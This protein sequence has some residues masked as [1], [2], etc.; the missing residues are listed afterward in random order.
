MDDFKEYTVTCKTKDCVNGG[1]GI[2]ML[3]PTVDPY[4]I[5]GPC[6]QPIVDVVG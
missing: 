3:A 5:C 4:F 2:T 1:I 6:G